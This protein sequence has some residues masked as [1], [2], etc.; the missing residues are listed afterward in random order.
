M[1]IGRVAVNVFCEQARCRGSE[2]EVVDGKELPK[3]RLWRWG[4]GD[5]RKEVFRSQVSTRSSSPRCLEV[6]CGDVMAGD[7][8]IFVFALGD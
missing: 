4:V 5:D 7:D 8:R 1:Q 2:W 3:L 6:S